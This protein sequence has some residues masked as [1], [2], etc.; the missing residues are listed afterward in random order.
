MALAGLFALALAG[1]GFHPVG[2][3]G[4]LP[5]AMHSTY[6]QSAEPYGYLENLLR[7]AIVAHGASVTE[8]RGKA[9]AVLYILD[10]NLLRRVL[11]VNSHGQPLQYDLLYEVRF[12][13]RDADG[14][15]LLKPQSI[16]LRRNFAYNVN[17]EL[18]ASRLKSQLVRDMQQEATR[19]IMLRIEALPVGS[20]TNSLDRD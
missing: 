5:G 18:G 2:S 8:Q 19:L 20:N 15:V 10:T 17:I 7:R 13:L 1:C 16:D 14:R 12:G 9:T 11:A 4:Q 6:V 3:D